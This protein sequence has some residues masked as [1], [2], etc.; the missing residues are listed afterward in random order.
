MR[1]GTHHARRL[2]HLYVVQQRERAVFGRLAGEAAPQPHPVGE[3]RPDPPAW[4][5]RG[6]R[7]LRN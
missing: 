3:L 4:I 7:I 1:I 5:E 6:Q 2:A